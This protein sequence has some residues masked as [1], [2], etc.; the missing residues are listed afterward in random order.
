[1][2]LAEVA[3]ATV[4]ELLNLAV[5]AFLELVTLVVLVEV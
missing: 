4:E 1:V 2:V 3:A 5:L